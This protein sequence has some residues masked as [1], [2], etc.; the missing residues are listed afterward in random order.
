M[1]DSSYID[2]ERSFREREK[3]PKIPEKACLSS[4]EHPAEK[5]KKGKL[6]LSSLR[7]VD[8]PNRTL[9]SRQGLWKE[10]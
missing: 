10:K 3:K 8:R 7:E 4:G 9:Y 6:C 2:R 5:E 1:V